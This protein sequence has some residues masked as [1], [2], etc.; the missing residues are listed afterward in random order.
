MANKGKNA[1]NTYPFKHWIVTEQTVPMWHKHGLP[2]ECLV[3][4]T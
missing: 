3:V 4:D 2:L 1:L